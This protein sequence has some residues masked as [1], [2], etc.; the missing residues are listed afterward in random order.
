MWKLAA[1]FGAVLTP[2]WQGSSQMH[3]SEG[4]LSPPVLAAGAVLAI[5]GIAIG[6]KKMRDIPLCGMLAAAFF[7]ASLIHVPVGLGN[8]HLLLVGL[9]GVLLGW[10]SFPAIFTALALQALLFQYGGITT[11]GVNTTTM[12]GGAIC[13]Y[14]LF[15]CILAV[16][17]HAKK[18]AAFMAGAAGIAVSGLLTAAA[19]AF[20][21][22]GFLA[23]A[24]ALL[25]AHIPIML[26]EG[27]LTMFTV[28]FLNKMRPTFPDVSP[29]ESSR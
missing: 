15:R 1:C 20:T 4:I 8:A 18:F 13:A 5:G 14:W 11:L 24:G 23:A 26:V 16:F 6:L 12:G 22:E 27:I 10:A 19:L 17:P 2:P 28:V 9:C 3:I 29:V 7:V 25:L 21:N